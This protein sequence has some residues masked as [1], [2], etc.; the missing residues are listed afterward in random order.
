VSAGS[1]KAL[2]LA[3]KGHK[4]VAI[5]RGSLA[6]SAQQ[7]GTVK[8]KLTTKALKAIGASPKS[9]AVALTATGSAPGHRDATATKK[10]KIKRP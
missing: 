9:V 1:A 8:V 3:A 10:L 6:I 4:P 5:G 2:G 7:T